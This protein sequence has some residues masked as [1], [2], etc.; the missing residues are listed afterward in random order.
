MY[1]RT[2]CHLCD[3]ARATIRA[4]AARSSFWFEEIHVDGDDQL[5]RD[6]GLRVP[7]VLV[8]DEE[9][10]EYHVDPGRL[11][12]LVAGGRPRRGRLGRLFGR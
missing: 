3:A 5:E 11:H 6:Y 10:F 7:V 2:T 12:A 1:S 9:A 4:E 8:D